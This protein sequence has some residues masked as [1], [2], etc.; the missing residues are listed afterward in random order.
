MFQVT[1]SCR[2]WRTDLPSQAPRSWPGSYQP[3]ARGVGPLGF[4]KSW[5]IPQSLQVSID[6]NTQTVQWLGWFTNFSTSISQQQ[7]QTSQNP[8]RLQM[9]L[10]CQLAPGRGRGGFSW[11]NGEILTLHPLSLQLITS[12]NLVVRRIKPC[13]FWKYFNGLL[14]LTAWLASQTTQWLRIFS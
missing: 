4:L 5:G 14:N 6:F 1:P 9:I 8:P 12:Q 13:H 2:P 11:S 3:E 10:P 7:Y